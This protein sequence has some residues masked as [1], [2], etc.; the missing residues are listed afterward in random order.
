MVLVT[1]QFLCVALRRGVVQRV[2]AQRGVMQRVGTQRD[3]QQL[4]SSWVQVR[5]HASAGRMVLVFE[6]AA[7]TASKCAGQTVSAA[8]C[9]KEG[10][11]QLLIKGRL[12][13]RVANGSMCCYWA[14]VPEVPLLAIKVRMQPHP[15]HPA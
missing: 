13:K 10:T 8:V 6:T 15:L 14:T 4:Q 12:A 2:A 3:Y 9:A 5:Q 7:I 11:P 1:G